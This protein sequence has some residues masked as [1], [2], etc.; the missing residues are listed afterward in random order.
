[1]EGLGLLRAEGREGVR[2]DGG[3]QKGIFSGCLRGELELSPE[4]GL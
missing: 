3:A 4:D 2:P 1:M